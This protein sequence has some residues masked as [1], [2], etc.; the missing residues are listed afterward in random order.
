MSG[1]VDNWILVLLFHP[2]QLL[3]Q[4]LNRLE[5]QDCRFDVQEHQNDLQF[6]TIVT[7]VCGLTLPLIWAR[8]LKV[9]ISV[10]GTVK[11]NGMNGAHGRTCY[12]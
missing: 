10:K 8:R 1:F 5:S 11:V 2:T 6:N 4:S 7:I 12:P 3:Y 9:I